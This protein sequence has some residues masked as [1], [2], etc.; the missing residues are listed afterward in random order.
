MCH[1]LYVA[2]PL[3]LSE[4]RSMLP[5]GLTADLV[6]PGESAAL[7]RHFPRGRTAARLLAG[8][9]SCDL[10]LRRDPHGRSEEAE[11]RRRYRALRLDRDARI[12]ALERHR[13]RGPELRTPAEWAV[14]LAAFVAE[15]ARNA[16][17]TLYYREVSAGRLGEI[18]GAPAAL[19]LAE[20]LERP[21][22]WLGEEQAVIVS[23]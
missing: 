17:P 21:G 9:C 12:R 20:V 6:T 5:A 15:H 22:T 3:T 2:T 14:Q 1:F 11:L 8:A 16:G 10:F 7:L 18:G 19:S 23:R 4:L 13:R